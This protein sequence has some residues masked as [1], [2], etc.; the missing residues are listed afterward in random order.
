[1]DLLDVFE[2]EEL[3]GRATAI[4]S[5]RAADASCEESIW[6]WTAPLARYVQ[7]HWFPDRTQ[8]RREKRND[9]VKCVQKWDIG[10]KD[11]RDRKDFYRELLVFVEQQ[12]KKSLPANFDSELIEAIAVVK[13]YIQ[14]YFYHFLR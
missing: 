2:D 12:R 4:A 11:D 14:Y 9:E 5:H 10:A 8:A 13:E 1:M 7:A 6:Y 3:L